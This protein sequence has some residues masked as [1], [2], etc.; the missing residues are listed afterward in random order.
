V[1]YKL[2][3]WNDG[4][5]NR[6]TNQ[7]GRIIEKKEVF[8]QVEVDLASVGHKNALAHTSQAFGF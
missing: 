5:E 2:P 7:V 8:L 6:S 3:V 4:S 1:K